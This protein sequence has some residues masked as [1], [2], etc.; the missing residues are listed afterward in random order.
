VKC[1]KLQGTKTQSCSG[2]LFERIT[3]YT[4]A[5][6]PPPL[7]GVDFT[8]TFVQQYIV[9][10]TISTKNGEA[11][12]DGTNTNASIT[13]FIIRY[14]P[15]ITFE[16]WIDFRGDRYDILAVNNFEEKGLFYSID[17]NKRGDNA[18][19]VNSAGD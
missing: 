17:T 6:T 15:G 14:I 3:I 5:I 1:V 10:A 11:V 9:W 4:R 8:E 18:L 16:N 13:N 7:D 12:F 2:D 19:P